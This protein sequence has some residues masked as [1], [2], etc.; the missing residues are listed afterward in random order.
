MIL[1]PY[2]YRKLFDKN[3]KIINSIWWII[4]Y[5]IIVVNIKIISMNSF[6]SSSSSPSTPTTDTYIANTERLRQSIIGGNSH[7]QISIQGYLRR[8]SSLDS[9]EEKADVQEKAGVESVDYDKYTKDVR[10]WQE[11]HDEFKKM[12]K[13]GMKDYNRKNFAKSWNNKFK[14]LLLRINDDENKFNPSFICQNCNK[15]LSENGEIKITKGNSLATPVFIMERNT[16]KSGLNQHEKSSLHLQAN[17]KA[18]TK[19]D[20]AVVTAVYLQGRFGIPAATHP[21]MMWYTD[22]FGGVHEYVFIFLFHA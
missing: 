20:A 6:I 18:A 5:L 2:K 8:S 3:G 11:V 17:G 9:I 15:Y 21:F 4:F 16:Q 22:K 14:W 1:V 19:S 13:N 7:H 10:A 12:R